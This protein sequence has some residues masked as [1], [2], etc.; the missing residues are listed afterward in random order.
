[1]FTK[2]KSLSLDSKVLSCLIL[3][4]LVV[5]ITLVATHHS[6]M[7]FTLP[8]LFIGYIAGTQALK[9]NQ[10]DANVLKLLKMLSLVSYSIFL[11]SMPAGMFYAS[12]SAKGAN[13]VLLFVASILLSII[14]FFLLYSMYETNEVFRNISCLY[15]VM[16]YRRGKYLL[17]WSF[18]DSFKTFGTDEVYQ[19]SETIRD[20]KESTGEPIFVVLGGGFLRSDFFVCA[21]EEIALMIKMRL[22]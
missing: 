19:F 9:L 20:I 11:L 8:G 4:A 18:D 2:W 17:P 16:K 22:L 12:T 6:S 15:R 21:N 13:Y 5:A 14:I 10:K 7:I 1:M 3:L